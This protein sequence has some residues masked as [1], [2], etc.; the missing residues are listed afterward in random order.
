MTASLARRRSRSATG[1]KCS[2]AGFWGYMTRW[3]LFA[4]DR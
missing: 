2:D 1:C 4:L 3:L